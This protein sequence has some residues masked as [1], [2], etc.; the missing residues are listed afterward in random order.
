MKL[1][2]MVFFLAIFGGC[3]GANVDA[4]TYSQM[5]HEMSRFQANCVDASESSIIH[6]GQWVRITINCNK[7]IGNEKWEN[8][9]INLVNKTKWEKISDE[10]ESLEFC[11]TTFGIYLRIS[12]ENDSTRTINKKIYISMR[13]PSAG[14]VCARFRQNPY[15]AVEK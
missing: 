1:F 6:K 13:Y 15:N 10:D 5:K 7:F 2:L 4:S 8:S 3:Q 14:A 9:A 12:E 11:H